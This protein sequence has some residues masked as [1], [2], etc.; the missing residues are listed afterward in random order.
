[1]T[2]P[3]GDGD[4]PCEAIGVG[5]SPGTDVGG[6]AGVGLLCDAGTEGDGRADGEGGAGVGAGVGDAVVGIGS[7][8]TGKLAAVGA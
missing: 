1:M 5:L 2:L 4:A 3:I 7:V 8:V 6:V